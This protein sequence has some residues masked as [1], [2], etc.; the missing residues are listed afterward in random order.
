MTNEFNEEPTK[1]LRVHHGA[2]CTITNVKK[3][4]YKGKESMVVTFAE[5]DTG[6]LIDGKFMISSPESK[7]SVKIGYD[8]KSC[9]KMKQVIGVQK[10]VDAIGKQLVVTVKANEYNGK[11]FYNP[12]SYAPAKFAVGFVP[13]GNTNGNQ[14][15]SDFDF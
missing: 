3:D 10:L 2:L 8:K 12:S 4:V 14:E 9:E 1:Y 5:N 13:E 15:N 11:V 6:A 7:D